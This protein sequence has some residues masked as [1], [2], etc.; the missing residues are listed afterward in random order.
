MKYDVFISYSRADYLDDSN[1]II[2]GSAIDLIVNAFNENNIKYWIDID[3][4]N[5]SNQYMA[6]IANAI[7]NSDKILY[8]SSQKTN[9]VESYWPIKEILYASEKHKTIIPI[10][11]DKSDFHKDIVLP[12]AG[13][14]IIEYYK[15]PEQS[16]DKLLKVLIGDDVTRSSAIKKNNK[17]NHTN[18]NKI[19]TIKKYL[20]YLIIF[21][22]SLFFTL[23]AI[24]S[25]GFG[26]GYLKTIENVDVIMNC[27]LSD[28]RITIVNHECIKYEGESIDFIYNFQ[29]KTIDLENVKNLYNQNSFEKIAMSAAIPLALENLSSKVSHVA[30]TKARIALLIG[31]SIGIFC[32]Y[33]IGE[34]YGVLVATEKNENKIKDYFNKEEVREEFLFLIEEYYQ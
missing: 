27:A 33:T 10:K 2:A 4:E 29:T 3:G 9:Q 16:I 17:E 25:V 7:S 14:D 31:G 5:A 11:I 6:K 22:F 1:T 18:K 34:H 21:I 12:L 28:G 8:V 30:D 19:S 13:L 15:N 20:G 26:V 24:G 32:G 23:S